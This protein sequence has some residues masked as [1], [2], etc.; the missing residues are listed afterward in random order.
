[1][2]IVVL[3]PG[4]TY[5]SSSDQSTVDFLSMT[6]P[7]CLNSPQKY[8]AVQFKKRQKAGLP[9]VTQTT[10]RQHQDSIVRRETDSSFS[11]PGFHMYIFLQ[12]TFSRLESSSYFRRV[13]SLKLDFFMAIKLESS[14]YFTRVKN[15]K[16]DF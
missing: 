12:E 6:P 4:T 9:T 13:K 11:G 8:T 10:S 15:L 1:M 5:F 2:H 16:L 3:Q 14:S 7:M